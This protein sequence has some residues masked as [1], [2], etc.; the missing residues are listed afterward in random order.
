M[1][2]VKYEQCIS[3]V[4]G[5]KFVCRTIKY[6]APKGR[7]FW[8]SMLRM[9]IHLFAFLIN[10]LRIST[11]D[12]NFSSVHIW[13]QFYGISENRIHTS[14]ACVDE[15]DGSG[16]EPCSRVRLLFYSKVQN[17]TTC[18]TDFCRSE[19]SEAAGKSF[20]PAGKPLVPADKSFVPKNY[21]AP[22]IMNNHND[23]PSAAFSIY[24]T[25]S[26][27]VLFGLL[28]VILMTVNIF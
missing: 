15:K 19:I 9:I 3:I 26:A 28:N 14:R 1:N 6:F 20:V 8:Y 23:K 27:Y 25:S 17:C 2:N 10:I 12:F 21:A 5:T 11:D 7:L 22:T 18:D 16:N 4:G 24:Q 13:I